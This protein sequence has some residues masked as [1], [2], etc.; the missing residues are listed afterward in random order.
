MRRNDLSYRTFTDEEISKANSVNILE[1]AQQYGFV[2]DEKH[3]DRKAV[4]LKQSGGLY[5]FPQSNRYYQHTNPDNRGGTVDF[6]MW[7]ENV[8]F[9]EAVAKLIG[10][11]YTVHARE[12]IPFEKEEKPPPVLPEAAENNKRVYSYLIYVRGL[13]PEIVN[14]F[15][16]RGMI[17]QTMHAYK[18]MQLANC[19]FVAYND[20]GIPKYCAVRGAS[21]RSNY[22]QDLENSDKSYPFFHE[23]ESDLVIVNE[24]PI[25][26]LSHAT[27]SKV[28][29]GHDWERDH[30]ISL[31]CLGIAALDRYLQSHPQI[32]RIVFAVDN[33]YLARDKDGNL[34]NWGQKA[35]TRWIGA[36]TKKG[37]DC[38][39]HVPRLNDF[40]KDLTEMRKGRT[41]EDLD[42]QRESE[43]QTEFEKDSKDE[44]EDHRLYEP[45]DDLAM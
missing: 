37:Y 24:A 28:F 42:R 14:E 5:I 17:Y 30:R 25:D 43:L 7:Q 1:L 22:R 41:P 3:K 36:Y 23:G 45:D 6:V 21:E 8:T 16:S 13:D 27:L 40:N 19:V 32:K 2:V 33:D 35:A 26:M 39:N 4:H 18:D 20:E 31:G 9:P 29:Y 12:I 15:I 34:A 11:E 44:P 10:E 38:A